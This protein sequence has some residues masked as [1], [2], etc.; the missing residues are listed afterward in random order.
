M[1]L[2]SQKGIPGNKKADQAA[3][4]A[5]DED[6]SSTERYPSDDLNKWL[7]EQDFK[8]RDQRWNNETTR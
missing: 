3:R 8:K 4:K 5:L 6:V 2:Q 7:T 1:S